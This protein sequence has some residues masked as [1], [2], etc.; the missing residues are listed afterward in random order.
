MRAEES[1]GRESDPAAR[2][3]ELAA[4]WNDAEQYERAEKAATEGLAHA[5]QAPGLLLQRARSNVGRQRWR[6]AAEDL[7]SALAIDLEYAPALLMLGVVQSQLAR[8]VDAEQ[9]IL[10][11]LRID[12]TW[13]Y[14]Y[15]AYGD[16]M[17]R[18][19][20]DAKAARLWRKA[21]ELDPQS[22]EAHQRLALA[23]VEENDTA[24]AVAHAR[25]GLELDPGDIAGSASLAASLL[26]SGRAFRARQVLREALSV[27][28]SNAQLEEAWL[29]ADRCCRWIYFPAYLFDVV[30]RRLPGKQFLPWAVFVGLSM[31]ARQQEWDWRYWGPISIAYVAFC[32]YTWIASWLVGLWIKLVPP[33]F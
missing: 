32:I 2:A 14:A 6:R 12:P 7:H 10:E 22:A 19:G 15:V 29:E 16:L 25:K 24:R 17:S 18:T 26:T 5:P 30:T 13:S 4:S 11:A 28:P 3:F 33:K 23:H 8:Y 31:V 20:H 27:D 21:L 9:H 1:V